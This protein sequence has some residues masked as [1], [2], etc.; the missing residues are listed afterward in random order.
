M[1]IV[2]KFYGIVIYFFF[3]G[4]NSPHFHAKYNE[5]EAL[6]DI[7]TLGVLKGKLPTKAL[8]LVIEWASNHQVELM[9]NWE[10]CRNDKTPNKIEPLN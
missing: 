4:H 3:N 8:G 7:K 6:I 10:L 2:S 1:L 9:N 5:F